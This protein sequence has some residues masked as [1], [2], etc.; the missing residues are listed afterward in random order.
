MGA[1]PNTWYYGG[2]VSAAGITGYGGS[3]YQIAMYYSVLENTASYYKI[4]LYATIN[5]YEY[6]GWSASWVNIEGVV[7]A[8]GN[9]YPN[10][11]SGHAANGPWYRDITINKT[12]N[13]QTKT[14]NASGFCGT[15]TA[16]GYLLI[17][18]PALATY[19]VSYNANGG[20]NAPGNQTKY[21]GVNLTL[22]ASKPVKNGYSFTRW[23]GSNGSNYNPGGTYTGNSN[24]ALTAEWEALASPIDSITDVVLST[25]GTNTTVKWTP[26]LSGSKFRLKLTVGNRSRYY[27]S[28]TTFYSTTGT[29]QVTHSIGS[30]FFTIAN[31]APQIVNAASLSCTASLETF[32]SNGTKLGVSQVKGFTVSV[33]GDIIPTIDSVVVAEG[34]TRSGFG[35]YV[36]GLSSVKTTVEA[37]GVYGSTISKVFTTVLGIQ[38]QA[39]LTEVNGVMKWVANTNALTDKGTITVT[40][41]VIDSRGRQTTTTR[42]ITVYEYWTPYAPFTISKSGS[43][44]LSVLIKGTSAPVNN[45]NNATLTVNVKK[46]SDSSDSHTNTYRTTD[47]SLARGDFTKN[48]SFTLQDLNVDTYVVTVTLKDSKNNQYEFSAN[49]ATVCISRL[50]GGEGVTFFK[51]ASE[52]GFW[53][54]DVNYDISAEEYADIAERLATWFKTGEH[55]TRG[56]FVDYNDYIYECSVS[57]LANNWDPNKWDLIV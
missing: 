3:S 33:P 53:I 54:R 14:Y 23:K 18:I 32:D 2:A 4:R 52:P 36:K 6:T 40:I 25:A 30:E 19:T 11:V 41:L 42:T 12:T 27:P 24:L 21:H 9:I 39:E 51:E 35:T 46:L 45:L 55:Y 31:L 29:S 16:T 1:S 26:I 22:S 20:Y 8:N 48:V 28:E 47:G 38:Y 57:H 34:A 15:G 10:G 56:D 7:V 37:S 50:G 43:T 17:D 13:W 49:T 44:T 5:F